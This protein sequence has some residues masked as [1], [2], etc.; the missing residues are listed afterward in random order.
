L[1]EPVNRERVEHLSTAASPTGVAFI[2]GG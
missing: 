1:G 2:R